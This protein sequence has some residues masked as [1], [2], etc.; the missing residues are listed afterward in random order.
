MSTD[1]ADASVGGKYDNGCQAALQ[2]SIE[3]GEALNVQHMH[4]V[5][6]QHAW[7]QLS[8][9]LVN[10]PVHHLQNRAASLTRTQTKSY[11]SWQPHLCTGSLPVAALSACTML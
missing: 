3:V 10:I 2:G 8:H 6:E 1:L 5:Y 7:H 9:S 11:T 4:L